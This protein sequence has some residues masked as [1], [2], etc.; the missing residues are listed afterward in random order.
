MS[1]TEQAFFIPSIPSVLLSRSG[2]LS[3]N[4]KTILENRYLQRDEKGRVKES[5]TE[6]FK[7]VA[8][9]VASVESEG[10][11]S[12]YYKAF[13]EL[14]SSRIF[15][16]NSPTLMNAGTGRGTL[17]ACFVLPLEDTMDGILDTAKAQGMTL[18]F[19]G[20]TGFN[21]SKI[22]PEGSPIATTHGKACGP[23]RTLKHLDSVS[24]LITQGG[25]RDGANMAILKVS[26]PDILD[27][28]GCKNSNAG[29]DKTNQVISEFNISISVDKNFMEAVE[30][31][32]SIDLEWDGKVVNTV[33]AR[34]L[35]EEICKSAWATGDPGVFFRDSVNEDNPT[36]HL[37]PLEC[38]NPCGEVPL[39]PN[40]ACN[41]GSI[42]L[43]LFVDPD[44]KEIDWEYLKI[45]TQLA[46]RFLDNVVSVNEYPSKEIEEQVMKTRKIG[47]GVMGWA[48]LLTLAD[49]PYE[50]DEAVK[51]GNNLMKFINQTAYLES[52]K[53][54]EERGPYLE[55]REETPVRNA[56]R[57]CIAPTGT[58][59]R[60]AG[61]NSGIEP[62]FALSYTSKVL[63]GEKLVDSPEVI[64]KYLL[65]KGFLSEE[66]RSGNFESEPLIKLLESGSAQNIEEL[67]QQIR[68]VLKISNEIDVDYHI[69]HQAAFQN[70]T[71]LAVSK[72]INMDNKATVEDVK[73]AYKL[74][75]RL[76]CKG[77]TIY[78]AGSRTFEVLTQGTKED[79]KDN[80]EIEKSEET[81]KLEA[82]KSIAE[83]SKMNGGKKATSTKKFQELKARRFKT[84]LPGGNGK[85]VNAYITVSEDEYG[86]PMEIFIN[87]GK[88]GG[89]IYADAQAIGRLCSLIFR[90]NGSVESVHKQLK[91][92]HSGSVRFTQD[93]QI[94]SLADA[95]SKVLETYMSDEKIKI[96][97]EKSVLENG[98]A[99]CPDCEE[100]LVF[101]EGCAKCV[102]PSCGFSRW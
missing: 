62:F 96:E 83:L 19:G 97:E 70:H 55:C 84:P 36:P 54:A 64:K 44:T 16:P 93:G 1:T 37:G 38:T 9:H 41:L 85:G 53:L 43:S 57:T 46:T 60:I 61:V 98:L 26:H 29:A 87:A 75:Y 102:S 89:D 50:S 6:L 42:N 79:K 92:I 21:L 78:R 67:P 20:G 17:S 71:N 49:I 72:T 7:R 68:E 76:G 81:E 48:D 15:L 5:A 52:V 45:V 25:K 94:F 39:Y 86:Y 4:T 91:G 35:F 65:D 8:R 47:L 30:N 22:R 58:I 101:E 74:A 31:D 3:S 51:L 23:I 18:K 33:S 11:R 27:F 24:K 66:I 59:A 2:P 32:G 95:V 88:S 77:I 69:R 73:R 56:T 100:P 90:N 40:E 10:K 34:Y 82:I 28:I 99:S 13:F 80:K 14:M 63:N 12:A